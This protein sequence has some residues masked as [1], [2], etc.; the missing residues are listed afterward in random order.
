MK[1]YLSGTIEE[2]LE[3]LSEKS[4]VPGGGSA[5]ALTAALGAALNL[6]VLEFSIKNTSLANA[7]NALLEQK[8]TDEKQNLKLAEL[9]INEDCKVFSILRK[10]I[11]E[12]KSEKEIEYIAAAKVPL[13]I[14]RLT[15]RSLSLTS[16]LAKN[17]NKNLMTDVECAAE[18]LRAAFFSAKKNVR[19]NLKYIKDEKFS[20]NVKNELEQLEQELKTAY[21]K[22][23]SK[24]SETT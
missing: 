17:A 10:A 12:K 18:T 19:I 21:N 23:L 11:S 2:Y 7:E 8:K 15:N 24:N 3:N 9:L 5:A 20:E 6:M 22:V 16:Y 1:N 13:E 14:C 4:A